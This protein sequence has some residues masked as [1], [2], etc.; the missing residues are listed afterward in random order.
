MAVTL[1]FVD[2]TNAAISAGTNVQPL[3]SDDKFLEVVG[4]SGRLAL[5]VVDEIKYA[6]IG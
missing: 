1:Y 6:T 2:N 3:A 5:A 4:D